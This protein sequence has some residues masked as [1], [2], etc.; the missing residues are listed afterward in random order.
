MPS[1]QSY[2]VV[3]ELDFLIVEMLFEKLRLADKLPNIP[4]HSGA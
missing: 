1:E 2:D 3:H 4:L